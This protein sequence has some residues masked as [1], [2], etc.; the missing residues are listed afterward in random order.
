MGKRELKYGKIRK[1]T[2]N[3]IL[4]KMFYYTFYTILP[5]QTILYQL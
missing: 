3:G 5:V 4:T 1:V 2:P